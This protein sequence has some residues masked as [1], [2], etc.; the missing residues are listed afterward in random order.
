MSGFITASKAAELMCH[1][2]NA[3]TANI[4][5]LGDLELLVIHGSNMGC[6]TS[7][8]IVITYELI[9]EDEAEEYLQTIVNSTQTYEVKK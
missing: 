4:F 9:P 6:T 2:T 3:I 7:G 5:N 8:C 1:V